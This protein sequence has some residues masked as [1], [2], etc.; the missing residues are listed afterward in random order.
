MI[1]TVA[2]LLLVLI[3]VIYIIRIYRD[4]NRNIE[5][6]R[7]LEE[8][9]QEEIACLLISIDVGLKKINDNIMYIRNHKRVNVDGKV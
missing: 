3:A 6:I 4:Y 9:R 5:E 2:Q 1:I 7:R 8:K